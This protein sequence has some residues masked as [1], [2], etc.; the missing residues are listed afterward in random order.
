MISREPHAVP[1]INHQPKVKL[2]DRIEF[3][4]PVPLASLADG[5]R[6]NATVFIVEDPSAIQV[7]TPVV[8]QSEQLTKQQYLVLPDATEAPFYISPP[9]GQYRASLILL[10]QR[11]P[12]ELQHTVSEKPDGYAADCLVKW[13]NQQRISHKINSLQFMVNA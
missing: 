9:T 6:F 1:V 3:N 5:E 4:L 12:V 8:Q 13:I 2:N 11:L 7:F 10:G